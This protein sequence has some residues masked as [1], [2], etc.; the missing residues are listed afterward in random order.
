MPIKNMKS[1]AQQ[2]KKIPILYRIYSDIKRY[3]VRVKVI[4]FEFPELVNIETASV[5]NLTCRHCPSH[6]TGQSEKPRKFGVMPFER[7]NKIMDEVDVYGIRN[8]SLHKDGEPL[9]NK[10]IIRIIERVKLNQNHYVYLTTNGHYLSDEII[11]A[12][13]KNNIDRVNISIGAASSE[14]YKDIRGGE[15]SK[16]IHNVNKLLDACD[17]H[18]VRTKVSVQIIRIQYE[19]IECEIEK[20]KEY[21]GDKNVDIEIWDELS[22]GIDNGQQ[23]FKFRYPCYALWNSLTINHDGLVSACCMDWN[24]SLILGDVEKTSIT[25]IWHSENVR[26]I[27]SRHIAKDYRSIQLCKKCNYWRWLPRIKKYKTM[28]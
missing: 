4:D 14:A 18:G 22:W 9:L 8:I 3:F 2:L 27:R 17:L 28:A 11:C 25:E 5:C 1:I 12:I 21:W 20:F 23:D 26:N 16:V 13:V 19:S 24:Q 7:F 15:L 10:E 6:A